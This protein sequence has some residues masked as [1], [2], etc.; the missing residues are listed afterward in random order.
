MLNFSESSSTH[1]YS[2][3]IGQ[4]IL[5]FSTSSNRLCDYEEVEGRVSYGIWMGSDKE[6]SM[7]TGRTGECGV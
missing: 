7:W 2:R 4:M 6:Y 3:D 1:L 5:K